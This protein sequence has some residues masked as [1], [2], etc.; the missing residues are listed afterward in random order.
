MTYFLKSSFLLC[1]KRELDTDKTTCYARES[2]RAMAMYKKISSP[3]DMIEMVCQP[4]L[5]IERRANF[6]KK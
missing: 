1:I 3:F 6:E 4:K 2:Q 5:K